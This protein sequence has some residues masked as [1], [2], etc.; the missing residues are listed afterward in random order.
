MMPCILAGGI[1]VS[2]EHTASV[3]RANAL[4]KFGERKKFS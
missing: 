4:Q 2:E 3:F 1:N